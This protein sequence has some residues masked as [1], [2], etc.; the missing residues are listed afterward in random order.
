MTFKSM[1]R[2]FHIDYEFDPVAVRERIDARCAGRDKS[3]PGVTQ[4]QRS[5][6]GRSQGRSLPAGPES[7]AAYVCVADGNVLVQVHKDPAY[8]AVVQ[9]AMFS[10]CDSSWVPVYL[11][12]LYGFKPEQ[13]C[14]SDIFRD[15]TG[16]RKYTMAFLGA[17]REVLDA[18][19]AE[20]SKAD[21][22]ILDMLFLE[23]P[24]A[25]AEDFDYEGIAATVNAAGPDI[26]WVALGAPK[27]EFFAARL[28][29]LLH[30]G[31]VIPVGAVFNFRAG[32]GIKRAPD[33]MVKMHLEFLYRLFS[34]PRK[35]LRR[36]GQILRY[37][38]AILREERNQR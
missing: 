28:T 26:V 5:E 31:V 19:R 11:K 37:T 27:Q 33:W 3:D 6:D 1:Q 32:L 13:Y 10:I 18:L 25:K 30:R 35:Q 22:R 4:P 12:R 15:L 8:R 21:P 20:L 14:G 38:P 9:G 17:S 36:V 16:A 24:F 29:P 2:Y 7:C 34:E 23:L